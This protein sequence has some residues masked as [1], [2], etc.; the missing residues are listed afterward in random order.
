MITTHILKAFTIILST[1][2]LVMIL[3]DGTKV[4]ELLHG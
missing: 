3:K 1:I 2:S 4:I